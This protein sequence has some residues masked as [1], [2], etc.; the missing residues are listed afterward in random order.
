MAL[1]ATDVQLDEATLAELNELIN[2]HT[3]S[4]PRY[5]AKNQQEVDSAE[6]PHHVL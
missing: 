6:Y 1:G 4:G 5:N 2:E 3:V